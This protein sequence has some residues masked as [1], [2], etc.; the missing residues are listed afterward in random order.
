MQLK[1]KLQML[2]LSV[3]INLFSATNILLLEGKVNSGAIVCFVAVAQ[4][5]LSIIHE[6]RNTKVSLAEKIIFLILYVA[7]GV[8]GLYLTGGVEGIINQPLD[9]LTII[10]AVFYMIAMFQKNEQ[11][12]RLILLINLSCWTVY[13]AIIGSMSLWAQIA[14]IISSLIG[15]YRYR[16]NGKKIKQ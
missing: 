4:L 13:L 10:A 1:K 3:F 9:L 8:F 14:G 7:G 11:H 6:I 16:K 2:T 5:I 12:I 15:L